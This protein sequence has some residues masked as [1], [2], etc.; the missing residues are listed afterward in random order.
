MFCELM[1][2]KNYPD[3]QLL[4]FEALWWLI[5]GLHPDLPQNPGTGEPPKFDRYQANKLIQHNYHVIKILK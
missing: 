4:V 3:H 5:C 1:A 2:I